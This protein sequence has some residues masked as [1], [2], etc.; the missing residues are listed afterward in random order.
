MEFL[1]KNWSN[2]LFIIFILLLIIPQTRTPIQVQLNRLIAFAPSEISE[3]KREVLTNYDWLLQDLEGERHTFRSSEGK[4]AVINLWATWCPPCIAEMP[5]F[6]KLYQEY[7]NK[8]D[9]YFVSSEETGKLKKFLEKKN[10][11]LPVYQPLTAGPQQL[12]SNSL[13]TTF[14]ISPSGEIVVNKTGAANW[15]DTK[16]KELLD[17]LAKEQ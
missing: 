12:Q 6:E 3:E 2:I 8:A 14:V 7:G 9:F 17:D 5:S 16:F 4:V 11:D 15:N 1:K 10:L 13:P